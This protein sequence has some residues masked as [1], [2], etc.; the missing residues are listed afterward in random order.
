MLGKG[1]HLALQV[2]NLR[3]NE[4]KLLIDDCTAIRGKNKKQNPRELGITWRFPSYEQF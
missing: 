2:E 4:I 1:K 3:N